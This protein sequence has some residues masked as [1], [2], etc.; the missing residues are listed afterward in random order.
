MVKEAEDIWEKYGHS[1]RTIF[2][3]IQ[4]PAISS[5]KKLSIEVVLFRPSSF[6]E[7]QLYLKKVLGLPS[8]TSLILTRVSCY[9]AL[10]SLRL[11]NI[12]KFSTSH[13]MGLELEFTIKSLIVVLFIKCDRK[14]GSK[15]HEITSMPI[16]KS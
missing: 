14:F 7:D 15:E 5:F 3:T 1:D 16:S 13:K 10:I 9:V 2:Q 8:S 12:F 6:Y 4:A 11:W